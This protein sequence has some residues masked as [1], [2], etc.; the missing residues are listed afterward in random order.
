MDAGSKTAGYFSDHVPLGDLGF[1]VHHRL[2]G[3]PEMLLEKNIHLF[4]D[5]ES[6]NG[7]MLGEGLGLRRM[8]P[9]FRKCEQDL[10]HEKIVSF[11]S[12]LALYLSLDWVCLYKK[13]PFDCPIKL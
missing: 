13:R 4:R 8:N 2:A 7:K 3:S 12:S 11:F 6:F 10:Y 1:L 5:W 9:A